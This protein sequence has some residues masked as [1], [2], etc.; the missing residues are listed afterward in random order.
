MVLNVAHRPK[1]F[2]VVRVC[3]YFVF[4]QS[5]NQLFQSINYNQQPQSCTGHLAV[6]A[7]SDIEDFK[8]P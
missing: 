8:T 6:L 7:K 2:T 3:V 1:D 5:I 4:L